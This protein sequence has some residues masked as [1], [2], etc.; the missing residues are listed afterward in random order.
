MKFILITLVFISTN[1]FA[2]SLSEKIEEIRSAFPNAAMA[3]GVV[4]KDKVIFQSFHGSQNLETQTPIDEQSLFM[5]GS[6]TKAFTS[7]ALG[8]LVE[9]GVIDWDQAVQSIIPEFQLMPPIDSSLITIRDLLLHMTGLPR[10]D[11]VWITQRF[12]MEHFL[13]LLPFLEPSYS[14]GEKWQYNNLMYM[15]AG[16]AA[17]RANNSSW[18]D[19]VQD[20]LLNELK[21]DSTYFTVDDVINLPNVATPYYYINGTFTKRKLRNIDGIGP[22]GSIH[23][24]INDMTKW[25]RMNLNKGTFSGKEIVS[26]NIINEIHRGQI[27]ISRGNWFPELTDS[28]YGFAWT[29]ANYRNHKIIRHGGSI[30]SYL[31][32]IAFFPEDDLGIII[33]T[34]GGSLSP[35]VVLWTLTDHFLKL[36]PIDWVKRYTYSKDPVSIPDNPEP[37]SLTPAVG[38]FTHTAYGNLDTSIVELNNKNYLQLKLNGLEIATIPVWLTDNPQVWNFKYN[39]TEVNLYLDKEN[40]VNKIEI[41]LEPSVSLIKFMRK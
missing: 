11:L 40:L 35:S 15:V 28:K 30:N 14:R 7:T 5:I 22:A 31:T 38:L 19:V 32:H 4:N 27:E 24:N 17:G 2:I 41:N 3:V 29:E 36:K 9:Q 1:V 12:S 26:R 25:L 8:K 33:L 39:G 20:Y 18:T 21:M 13:S 6:T 10:H 37:N 34:S 23:S 16:M